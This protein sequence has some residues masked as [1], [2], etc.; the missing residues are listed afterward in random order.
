MTNKRALTGPKIFL[1]RLKELDLDVPGT[2]LINPDAESVKEAQKYDSILIGRLDGTSY[3]DFS[4][5]ESLK[6]FLELRNKLALS[7]S[8]FL[9]PEFLLNDKFNYVFNRFL[10]RTNTWLLKNSQGVVFQ[11][12][13]SLEMH[14]EF[15]SF[16]EHEKP[17][18]VIHNGVDTN[19]FTPN[20]RS[21]R[22]NKNEINL[23]V[24]GSLFRAHKRLLEAIRLTNL[25]ANVYSN[26]K[27]TILG[28]LDKLTERSIE[29]IDKSHCVF[30]GRVDHKALPNFYKDAD[31]QLHLS[32]FDPCPNVVV[33]GLSCGLPV[34]TPLESGASELVGKENVE[35]VIPENLALGYYNLHT[36]EKIPTI[37]LQNYFDATINVLSNLP[38]H[39]RNARKRAVE[40]LDIK[41]IATQYHEFLKKVKNSH[42]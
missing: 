13:L 9:I 19:A 16:I 41:H 11:S 6:N 27:L 8:I 21:Y 17:H 36:V 32:I 35:W 14:K 15:L 7:K 24:S 29:S 23:I 37:P 28:D 18:T 12:K 42:E 39:Q 34:I 5:K 22:S 38:K 2:K 31:L 33:E 30:Q 20:E 40:A 4:T 26:I 1:E 10:D 25:L 3:Y